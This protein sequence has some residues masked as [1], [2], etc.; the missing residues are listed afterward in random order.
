MRDNWAH[1]ALFRDT[2]MPFDKQK[3]GIPAK[4]VTPTLSTS[5]RDPKNPKLAGSTNASPISSA[6]RG[7]RLESTAPSGREDFRS[8][9]PS[10][11]HGNV[12]PR[13]GARVSRIGGGSPSTPASSHTGTPSRT[14]PL[15][16][17]ELSEPRRC[18]G[19]GAGL[20]VGNPE[21]KQSTLSG[22][23]TTNHGSV[24]SGGLGRRVSTGSPRNRIAQS[25]SPKLLSAS[26][27]PITRKPAA[28]VYAGDAG[29]R[30]NSPEPLRITPPPA[31]EEELQGKFC[32]ANAKITDRPLAAHNS[33]AAVNT[34]PVAV[35]PQSQPPDTQ[36]AIGIQEEPSSPAKPASLRSAPAAFTSATSNA[37]KVRMTDVSTEPR[38]PVTS[39][40]T[41]RRASISSRTSTIRRTAQ[42]DLS[43]VEATPSTPPK[44]AELHISPRAYK[45][46][47]ASRQTA[48]PASPTERFSPRSTSLSSSNTAI[49]SQTLD[50]TPCNSLHPLSPMKADVPQSSQL[51][52]TNEL[53]ANARRE[54]KVLDLEISN[55]SLLAINRTLEREMRKQSLE[56]RRFRRVS[57][58]GQMPIACN[59]VRSVSGQSALSTVTESERRN[60]IDTSLSDL[61]G[62]TTSSGIEESDLDS[63]FGDASPLQSPTP[64]TDHEA[65]SYRARD[66]RRLMLDLS[67]H[68]QLLVDSQKV[69]QSIKRC[70][71]WTEELI[72]EGRT[73]LAY[74]ATV[75]DV[76]VGGKM[77]VHRHDQGNEGGGGG[78][79]ATKGL[80]NVGLAVPIPAAVVEQGRRLWRQGLEEIEM[81]VDRMLE[82]STT[83][84]EDIPA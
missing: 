49:S 67:K 39:S 53:A 47:H 77:L 80:S 20:G 70:V 18:N 3:S 11:L 68:R 75:S 55:S 14:R 38:N 66:Q 83:L 63:S 16:A 5:F 28:F 71:G 31:L 27:A 19:T 37:N 79:V 6:R 82:S 36:A 33:A 8:P 60:G 21:H 13:S 69:N 40:G 74:H 78:N 81:E 58:S 25:I 84:K 32:Y 12:T 59:S 23:T 54:R 7:P 34:P 43:I 45:G 56:L 9:T 26:G 41:S 65:T 1:C 48:V 4:P 24:I 62:D 10:K 51:H 42:S 64:M 44:K 29:R 57:R 35:H 61:E 52:G 72:N 17:I 73:A 2:T 50:S 22:A 46:Q 15:S 30:N 76:E